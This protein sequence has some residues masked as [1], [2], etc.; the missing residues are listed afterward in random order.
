MPGIQKLPGLNSGNVLAHG[1]AGQGR[2]QR[3]PPDAEQR[4]LRGGNARWIVC[5]DR[6]FTRTSNV[7][8]GS[9]M[10]W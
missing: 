7:K 1:R 9:A 10:S 4:W 2:G 6:R 5:R 8:A 3:V